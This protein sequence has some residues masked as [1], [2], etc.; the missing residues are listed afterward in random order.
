MNKTVRRIALLAD[1]SA[2]GRSDHPRGGVYRTAFALAS[3]A[4]MLPATAAAAQETEPPP[5]PPPINACGSML[6][7]EELRFKIN[8]RSGETSYAA[9]GNVVLRI[10][11][12]DS[13]VVVRL[14][15]RVSVELT[16]TSRTLTNTGRTLLIPDPAVP[17]VAESIARAGLP[18]LPLISG[19]VVIRETLDPATGLAIAGDIVSVRG[20]V[21]DVCELLAR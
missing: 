8:E 1:A 16:E 5:G 3:A 13:S 2:E 10:S 12:E 9:S 14:P 11:D 7:V 4:L 17:F 20:R 19:R 15:G 6:T 21:V 18:E